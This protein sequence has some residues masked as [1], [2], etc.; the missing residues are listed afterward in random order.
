MILTH[1]YDS[2]GTIQMKLTYQVG[3]IVDS[4]LCSSYEKNVNTMAEQEKVISH[5]K[6]Q[7]TKKNKFIKRILAK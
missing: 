2:K 6:S 5:L 7:I 3:D 1:I 4:F